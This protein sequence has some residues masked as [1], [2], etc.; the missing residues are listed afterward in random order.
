MESTR[1]H[2]TRDVVRVTACPDVPAR[3]APTLAWS[4]LLVATS[5]GG[6]LLVASAFVVAGPMRS[7]WTSAASDNASTH[8]GPRPSGTPTVVC[9]GTADVRGGVVRLLPTVSGRVLAVHVDDNADVSAGQILLTLDDRQARNQLREAEAALQAAESQRHEARKGPDQHKLLVTQQ[10]AAVAAVRHELAAARL[11]AVHKKKL[12][13]AKQLSQEEADAAVE[14]EQ[15]LKSLEQVE[16][17]KLE[18]LELRDPLQELARAEAEV[19]AKTAMRDR[20]RDALGEYAL[21]APAAGRVLRV[22]ANPGDL[23]GPGQMSEALLFCPAGP[24]VVRA[25]VEQEYAGR[26]AIGQQAVIED[27]A[28]SGG[29]NWNGK[30]VRIADWFTQRRIVTPDQIPVQEVRT[31]ECLVELDPN[32]PPLRIGQRVR[33]RLYGQ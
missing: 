15:K 12:M 11:A 26:V 32:Q 29:P 8:L 1:P 5:L 27:A 21:K 31:L 3:T 16:T 4:R 23:V 22:L 14:V 24:R 20:A 13:E 33:V 18:A 25:E 9:L 10:K 28:R 19:R 7:G 6:V 17:A 30:V 2:E